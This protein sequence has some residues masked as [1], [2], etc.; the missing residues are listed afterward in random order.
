MDVTTYGWDVTK[1]V[2]QLYW[3][4]RQTGEI[5]NRQMSGTST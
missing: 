3:V 1:R 2:F 5:C 4:D